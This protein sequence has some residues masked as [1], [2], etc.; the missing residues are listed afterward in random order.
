[1]LTVAERKRTARRR[2]VGQR[3]GFA[4]AF[5]ILLSTGAFL[6]LWGEVTARVVGFAHGSIPYDGLNGALALVGFLL[7]TPLRFGIRRRVFFLSVG[8]ATPLSEIF[9]P[10]GSGSMLLRLWGLKLLVRG[11][12]VLWGL[13]G[14][15]SG[16]VCL[17]LLKRAG[18]ADG[19]LAVAGVGCLTLGWAMS[20]LS[21]AK[22]FLCE[23]LLMARPDGSPWRLLRESDRRMKG[24]IAHLFELRLHF[25]GWLLLG[26]TGVTL[27]C[28]LTYYEMTAAS[29]AADWI[30]E[31]V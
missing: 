27:P 12:G 21:R 22:S 25:A 11:R 28:L 7:L 4:V 26:L 9:V 15:A 19:L 3:I 6:V 1:M 20:T 24:K 29:L 8:Q 10:F 14:Y 30:G 17:A 13:A 31:S 2:L 23:Y 5:G 16:G 18:G